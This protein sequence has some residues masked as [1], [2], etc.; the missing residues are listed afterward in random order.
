MSKFEARAAEIRA[1]AEKLDWQI[2]WRRSGARVYVTV[3]TKNGNPLVSGY[4]DV[5]KWLQK[6]YKEPLLTSG[7]YGR[8]NFLVYDLIEL[9]KGDDNAS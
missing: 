9:L 2:T 5:N 8:W 4:T 7:G 3:V 6:Y 1:A